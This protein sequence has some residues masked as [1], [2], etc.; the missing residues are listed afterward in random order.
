MTAR[1]SSW[2][3]CTAACARIFPKAWTVAT[4][5]C[6]PLLGDLIGLPPALVITCELDPLRD[7]GEQLAAKLRAEHRRVPDMIHGWFQFCGAIPR[8]R[9]L[10]AEVGA[11]LR[12]APD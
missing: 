7:E 6:P 5:S 10:I 8:G 3:S 2:K 11:W 1:W 12:V 4:R 9:E